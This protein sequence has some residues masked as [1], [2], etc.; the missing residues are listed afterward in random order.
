MVVFCM[1]CKH[2]HHVCNQLNN[3][4]KQLELP[5]HA[6]WI[7]VGE[8]LNETFKSIEENRRLTRAFKNGEFDI[9]VQVG[10]AEEGFDVKQ[11]SVLLFLHLIESDGK[12]MQQIGRGL[13]RNSAIKT[14][15]DD[16]VSGY[17]S[18]D[19]TMAALIQRMQAEAN[20]VTPQPL[21]TP[22]DE[23]DDKPRQLPLFSIPD[24]ILIDARYDRTD[25]IGPDGVEILTPDQ[26]AFCERFNIPIHDYLQ[27]VGMTAPQ[28]PHSPSVR[29]NP[30]AQFDE[31]CR[32][33]QTNTK[34]LAGNIIK[35]LKTNGH[36]ITN[37]TAGRVKRAIN[38]AWVQVSHI[39]HK[40]MTT[41]E[42]IRKNKWLQSVNDELKATRE[43][44]SWI[45]TALS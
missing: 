9:L 1:T 19:T 38:E 18:A 44:P 10:K 35:L 23:D 24:V 26:R 13:R 2:A 42:F 43:I 32:Q 12:R 6:E 27:H 37:E 41:D 31:V 30:K 36:P 3:L 20:E 40:S 7:G 28:V 14:F 39:P 4:C 8:G 45:R 33:V 5:F 16:T 34:F 21:D 29:E 15:E 11:I 17:A 22:D 25:I